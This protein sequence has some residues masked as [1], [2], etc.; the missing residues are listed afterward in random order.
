MAIACSLVYNS[1]IPAGRTNDSY[2]PLPNG[3]MPARHVHNMLYDTIAICQLIRQTT[4][5]CQLVLITT[6]ICQ[7][8]HDYTDCGTAC[9]IYNALMANL[10]TNIHTGSGGQVTSTYV[11]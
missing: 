5:V 6:A 8:V 7:L 11:K 1:Y 4:D 2:A 3:Y 10:F 9:C